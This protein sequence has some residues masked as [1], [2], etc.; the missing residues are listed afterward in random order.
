M[1]VTDNEFYTEIWLSKKR[2]KRIHKRY[3]N[4]EKYSA[5]LGDIV[6]LK[7][8]HSFLG[9]KKYEFHNLNAPSIIRKFNY[10]AEH[11][12]KNG[13]AHRNNGVGSAFYDLRSND[14]TFFYLK[15]SYPEEQYWN[16]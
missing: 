3:Y 1:I 12:Y 13:L 4:P 10:K 8:T 16:K 6:Y 9:F 7:L 15:I 5:N 14:K 11:W 2:L